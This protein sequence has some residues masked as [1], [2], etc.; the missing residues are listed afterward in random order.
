MVVVPG[1]R[2]P[3]RGVGWSDRLWPGFLALLLGCVACVGC[4][5]LGSSSRARDFDSRVQGEYESAGTS[6]AAQV[7]ALGDGAFDLVLL[8]DGLPGRGP[9][10]QRQPRRRIG[11]QRRGQRVVFHG[12]DFEAVGDGESLRGTLGRG[13]VFAMRRVQ[14]ESPTLLAMP[15][16]GAT[17]LFDGETQGFTGQVDENGFLEAGATSLRRFRDFFLH[18]EFRTPFM[19]R[20]RGQGRGNSGVYLQGRYEIQILD[21]FGLA[22]EWNE[23]GGVYEVARPRLNMSF[24]PLAWQTYDID[25]RAARFGL[26]GKRVEP[27]RVSV[28]HNG[29]AIHR[30]RALFGPTGQGA[31]ET[32]DA[33]ALFLQDHWNPVVFRNLWIVEPAADATGP[34]SSL[35]EPSEGPKRALPASGRVVF[36]PT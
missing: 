13:E 3:R 12:E 30:D 18:V 14:R 6:L 29:V 23:C 17:V 34:S 20:A 24:P 21:S 4:G 1:A 32:P 10:P 16:A 31:P 28:R 15:P 7:I 9:A 25:F 36:A 35:S 5:P 33:G 8:R 11:G 26:D 22:G 27:A 19:P 2:A